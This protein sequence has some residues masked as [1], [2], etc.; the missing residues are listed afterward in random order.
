[1]PTY[2]RNDFIMQKHIVKKR[3][4]LLYSTLIKAVLGASPDICFILMFV[5]LQSKNGGFEKTVD[6]P[7]FLQLSSQC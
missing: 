3:E 7:R 6:F 1:M 4:T 5:E 2:T